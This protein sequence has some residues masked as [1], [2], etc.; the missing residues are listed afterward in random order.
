MQ[1]SGCFAE[2]NTFHGIMLGPPKKGS[3]QQDLA[4]KMSDNYKSLLTIKQN[5]TLAEGSVH[6]GLDDDLMKVTEALASF[7][8]TEEWL[9]HLADNFIPI[10]VGGIDVTLRS[11]VLTSIKAGRSLTK[12]QEQAVIRS[13]N[14]QI[15]QF[16]EPTNSR[17]DRAFSRCLANLV[18][19]KLP[20][21]FTNYKAFTNYATLR[22]GEGFDKQR[23]YKILSPAVTKY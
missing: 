8:D 4:L 20:E 13:L 12:R 3:T 18:V 15:R 19:E 7:S 1:V 2:E 22:I 14:Q 5:E 10:V 17:L 9:K 21:T 11:D 23:S 6:Q 16:L